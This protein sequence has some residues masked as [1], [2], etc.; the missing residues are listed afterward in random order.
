[1]SFFSQFA[2]GPAKVTQ[3]TSGSGT[4]T[5]ISTNQSWA[6]VTVVG[7]GGGGAGPINIPTNPNGAAGGGGGST[8]VQYIKLN[9]ASYSYAVGA[10]GN[11]GAGN[12]GNSG[13]RSYFGPVFSYGGGG[14]GAG[15]NLSTDAGAGGNAGLF[16]I[17]AGGP[18][19]GVPMVG[20][21]STGVLAGLSL[22]H[23]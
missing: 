11:G 5:P 20:A 17:F 6:R 16:P 4:Y 12:A 8:V 7:G 15:G 18:T 1:M 2:G 13:S 21:M 3:Y 14:G 23:I 9:S 19:F 10:G 22:I